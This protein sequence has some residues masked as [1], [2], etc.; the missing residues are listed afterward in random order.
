LPEGDTAGISGDS[1]CTQLLSSQV[2]GERPA[3]KSILI[4]A[5]TEAENRQSQAKNPHSLPRKRYK[6]TGCINTDI[7][8]LTY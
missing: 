6:H 8:R 4:Y 1:L 3:V 2:T 7:Q 5:W